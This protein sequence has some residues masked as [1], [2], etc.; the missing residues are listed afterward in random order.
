MKAILSFA[1]FYKINLGCR[2]H[3][4]NLVNTIYIFIF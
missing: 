4:T 3:P 1:V 2:D